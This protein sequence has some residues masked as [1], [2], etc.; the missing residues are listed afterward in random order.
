MSST[1]NGQQVKELGKILGVWAHPDDETYMAGGLISI[2]ARQNQEVYCVTA[3]RGEKG[4]QDEKRWPKAQLAN[5]RTREYEQAQ[6]V[7]GI[8]QNIW[9]DIP[10]GQCKEANTDGKFQSEIERLV[11]EINPDTILTF[12]PDGLTGHTDHQAVSAW[13]TKAGRSSGIDVY[14]SVFTSNAYRKYLNALNQSEHVDDM[15]FN[16][17]QPQLYS[18]DNCD[19]QIVLDE[20][21]WASK[22]QA[23]NCM[24]S[25]T[26]R[27]QAQLG[28]NYYKQ[29]FSGEYFKKADPKL[30]YL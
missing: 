22:H 5:I 10:D 27:L 30:V 18:P 11:E 20:G 13:A 14:H 1:S 2:A 6:T 7:L 29:I 23:L 28:S 9:L 19:I 21:L 25:Q 24:P 8:K 12:G 3:T 4:V 17:Y 15:F 26:E 16:I